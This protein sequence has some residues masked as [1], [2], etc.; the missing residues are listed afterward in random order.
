MPKD[1]TVFFNTQI[2]DLMIITHENDDDYKECDGTGRTTWDN[3]W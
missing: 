3:I 1:S 2:I